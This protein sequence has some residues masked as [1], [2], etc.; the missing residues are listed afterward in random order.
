MALLFPIFLACKRA[1][2]SF[3]A[4]DVFEFKTGSFDN[5]LGVH[6]KPDQIDGNFFTGF[7]SVPKGGTRAPRNDWP[8]N[9]FA[10]SWFR[11]QSQS[12]TIAI[13]RVM[14]FGLLID[15]LHFSPKPGVGFHNDTSYLLS[16]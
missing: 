12:G 7:W 4:F 8:A 13:S 14:M 6:T 10:V 2:S 5:G 16:K 1:V 11:H 15:L 3:E 9:H